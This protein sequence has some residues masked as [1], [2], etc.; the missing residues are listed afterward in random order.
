MDVFGYCLLLSPKVE[1]RIWF[2]A[3]VSR[4]FTCNTAFSQFD[5]IDTVKCM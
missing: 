3:F 4:C 5:Y 2:N 1:V